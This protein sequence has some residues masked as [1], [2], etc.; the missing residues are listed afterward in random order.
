MRKRDIRIKR[1]EQSLKQLKAYK[2]NND[3]G[4]EQWKE[5]WDGTIFSSLFE[6][7]SS[8]AT[9]FRGMIPP[10]FL[11]PAVLDA[12]K[13][14]K[15]GARSIIVPGEADAYCARAVREGGGG[16]ILTNDSDLFLY[17][18]GPHG[19]F[20]FIYAAEIDGQACEKSCRILRLSVFRPEQISRR[21]GLVDLRR[22][23]FVL[24]DTLRLTE[25]IHCA[26]NN[27]GLASGH[28]QEFLDEYRTE[29]SSFE[30][31]TFL[32][33]DLACFRGIDH[34]VL[35]PRVSELLL[36]LTATGKDTVYMYLPY[37]IDDSSR[38]SAWHVSSEQRLFAYSICVYLRD[39]ENRRPKT[40]I[41]E[42]SRKGNRIIA[43]QILFP[44]KQSFHIQS[45]RLLA[46]LRDLFETFVDFPKHMI[47]RAYA[48]TEV[49]RWY[50]DTNKTP[51][52]RTT[53]KRV[54][55]GVSKPRMTWEDIH[56]SAQ[57]QAVV[58]TLRMTKQIL[59]FTAST[60]TTPLPKILRKLASM[61][62]NLPPLAQ[63]I[64]SRF[65]LAAQM[66]NIAVQTSGLD[67]DDLLNHL[68]SRLQS[69]VAADSADDIV[70]V[71]GSKGKKC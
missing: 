42:C 52:T 65:E 4:A 71:H 48:L 60:I 59:D 12:I 53:M 32:P 11:V 37:L 62:S 64:P 19:A 23:A 31:R 39:D 9:T 17:D 29:P 16:I 50:L 2:L 20:C 25:A 56:L 36:Q 24:N 55:T 35:D 58:Y 44:Q 30:S 57:I 49:Y 45:N 26:K 7:R 41:S 3:N 21:L 14:S 47:W 13:G 10:P 15:Y 63:L 70:H 6:A 40:I 28:Y 1:L 68:A 5:S 18:L 38:S 61:L 8:P 46:H 51:P 34:I 33:N 22:L 69:E 27:V 67:I 66:S 43:Q 54:M